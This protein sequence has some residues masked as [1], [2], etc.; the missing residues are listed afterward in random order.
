MSPP[1]GPVFE[2]TGG[3][4]CLDLANTLDE[5]RAD[6]PKELLH[7]YSDLVAWATQA[8]AIDAPTARLLVREAGRDPRGAARALARARRAREELFSLFGA[9]AEGRP[10]PADVLEA[11]DPELSTALEARR[12][13]W[14]RHG[15]AW[16]WREMEPLPLDRVLW[17]ALLS[18]AELLTS[19]D[20]GRVRKCEGARCAWL[21]LDRS[22]NGS[23]RWCDMTICGN[24]AKARRHQEKAKRARSGKRRGG[25]G[26]PAAGPAGR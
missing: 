25:R 22:R 16:E 14:G 9:V 21:F 23:R 11:L 19:G 26:S 6:E 20:V 17:A 24:R 8:G 3:H 12:L 7:D 4:L 1:D 2:I 10:A 5:R 18:A 13:A 15:V